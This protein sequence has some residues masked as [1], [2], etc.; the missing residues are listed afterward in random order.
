MSDKQKLQ[1]G[2]ALIN[3]VLHRLSERR[4]GAGLNENNAAENNPT[5]VWDDV[6]S[7]FENRI[8]TGVITNRRH[9]DLLTFM[10][11]AKKQFIVKV[12]EALEEHP[13]LKVNTVLAAEYTIVKD[14]EE[15][16]DI[17]YF[18]T[19]TAPIYSTTD[20][21]E[22]FV[23]NVQQPIDTEMEEFQERESGWSL[24]SILNLV[25]NIYKYN[26]M[27]DLHRFASIHQEQEGVCQRKE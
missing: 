3:S 14:N 12:T 24:K 9:L 7:A 17:K 22:W 20:L 23:M 25:I 27:R 1:A 15:T 8:K 18:N 5:V 11:D 26:P 13:A 10:K 16:V 4:V 6:Q 2:I 21:N 19:K